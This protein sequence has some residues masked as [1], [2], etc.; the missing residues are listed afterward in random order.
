M[1]QKKDDKNPIDLFPYNIK[2][3]ENFYYRD[4]PDKVHPDSLEFERYWFE[5]IKRMIEGLWVNDEGTWVYMPPKLY[6]YVNYCRIEDAD[7]NVIHPRLRDIEWIIFTYLLCMEGFSGFEKDEEYTCLADIKKI[8]DGKELDPVELAKIPDSAKKKDG[9]YK[10][11]INAWEYLTRHYLLDSPPDEPLGHPLYENPRYNAIVLS[12]RGIGKSLSMFVG[13]F[14]H[15]FLTSGI[16]RIEEIKNINKR[17]L[18]AMGS[19][20]SR[21]LKRS[22]NN[23]RAFYDNQPG[24]YYYQDD[25][26]P[27]KGP[28]YKNLQGTWDTGKEVYHIVKNKD[29]STDILGSS[30]QMVVLTEDRKKV[31]AGDRFRRIYIEEFGFLSSAIDVFSANRD[32]LKVGGKRVGSAVMLGTGGDLHAIKEPKKMFENPEAYD[33]F[34]IPNYWKNTDKK[35]GLFIPW[36]YQNE[37]YKD[38]QGNTMLDLAYKACLRERLKNREEMDSSSYEYS[39]MFNPLTPDEMLRPSSV[40][41]LPRV[42]AG[43]QLG[44][45]EDY[46]IFRKRAMIGR[47][48]YDMNED[49]GVRFEKDVSGSLQPIIEYGI[50]DTKVNKDGAFIMYEMPPAIIPD[51][52]YWVVYDPAK[53][54]GDGESFHSVI[55]YKGFYSGPENTLYDTIVGEWIGR[56]ERLDDNFDMVIRIAMFFNAKIFPEINAPGFVEY[57]SK[58]EFY[59]LL[60]PDAYLLEKEISPNS[61]RSY[62]QVGFNMTERKKLWCLKKLKDW[63]LEVKERDPV[64]GTPTVTTMDWI[65]SPRVLD[66]IINYNDDDNFDHIS[67]LLGLMLLLGKLDKEVIELDENQDDEITKQIQMGQ[68]A[69]E[70]S[71]R[72][73]RRKRA[74]FLNY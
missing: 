47:L 29:G 18:F 16:K 30:V 66:E 6:T 13:D 11:Y 39:V 46:D 23:I 31:G 73:K 59:R 53:K 10:K 12:C 41:F 62:Y 44:K 63:L 45:L 28:M 5:Q 22:I 51:N 14:M 54:S 4:H 36:Y 61:K 48:Q 19:A 26:A 50:D 43:R 34:G 15:E 27:Y 69:L 3:R 64:T 55:V 52:L 65:F 37:D 2:S 70:L 33:V 56:K 74:S 57:C 38:A 35:I 60:E 58:R 20:D 71:Q 7:R 24:Q 25:R 68:L 49:R 8:E 21:P 1:Q 67:S 42:E 40:G 9:S 72:E 17:L 32:S